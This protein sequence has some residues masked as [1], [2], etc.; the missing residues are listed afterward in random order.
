MKKAL[1]ASLFAL[2]LAA[3]GA[4]DTPA[5]AAPAPAE[6]QQEQTTA[7]EA[8]DT[9]LVA[10]DFEDVIQVVA[11]FSILTDM[12]Y[13]VGRDLVD[14]Y[15]I[16]PIGEEPEEHELLPS[17]LIAVANADLVFFNGI[18][19]EEGG[20]WFEGLVEATDLVEGVNLFQA[21]AG[22][23]PFT[24]LTEGME[25]YYD[26]H[27][28]LDIRNG[29]VYIHNIAQVLSNFA[30][31]HADFFATNAANETA[32]LQ[33]L[34]DSWV[35]AFDDIP[36]ERRIIVTAE[37]AFRYMSYAYGFDAEFIWELNAEE[38]GTIEQMVRIIDIV[39]NR[40]IR[41]LFVESSVEPDY[42]EQVSEETGVPIFG[43]LFTDSLSYADGE[44]P[45]YFDM[46]RHNLE[47]INAAFRSN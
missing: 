47:T 44:A 42:I 17:D 29:I 12:I 10:T 13:Q 34:H 6:P 38:E 23:T 39:N 43:M 4:A 1:S 41:Y 3:C 28:W 31:E 36:V 22:I 37:G 40:D 5:P 27:A 35:G 45:T 26:P 11:T 14:I 24:L 46:M 30:P 32:R 33:A 20:Y 15:T 18:G 2:F 8:N 9:E 19:L 25:D 7:A 21:S 16:V